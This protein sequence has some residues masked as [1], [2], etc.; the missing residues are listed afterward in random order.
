M[1]FTVG[2]TYG[3]T[4]VDIGAANPSKPSILKKKKKTKNLQT[5]T[6]L[7][8]DLETLVGSKCGGNGKQ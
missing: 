2:K 1:P 4:T 6:V 7:V 3:D 5:G 8:G